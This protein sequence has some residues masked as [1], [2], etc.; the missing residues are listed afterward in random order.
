MNFCNDCRVHTWVIDRYAYFPVIFPQQLRAS[1]EELAEKLAVFEGLELDRQS[2][3]QL[4]QEVIVATTRKE[5]QDQQRV[6]LQ[7]N[8]NLQSQMARLKMVAES[9]TSPLPAHTATNSVAADASAED[10][11]FAAVMAVE[12]RL[13]QMDTAR[14]E[15]ETKLQNTKSNLSLE[16]ETRKEIQ[17]QQRV[18]VEKNDKLHSQIVEQQQNLQKNTTLQS[19]MAEQQRDLTQT[20]E[21]LQSQIVEQQRALNDNA[22]LQSQTAEQQSTLLQKT[23]QLQSQMTE[24]QRTLLQTNDNLQSQIAEQQRNLMQTTDKLQSQIAEQQRNLLHTNDKLQSQ[25]AEQQRN[26]MQTNDK[27]QSQMSEQQRNLLHTNDTLQSQ[28]TKHQRTLQKNENLQSQMARLKMVADSPTSPLPAHTATNSVS[29][30]LS[31]G[32]PEFAA[33]LAVE[34]RLRQMDT[35][36]QELETKLKSMQS[37]VLFESKARQELHAHATERETK[38]KQLMQ[39]M[40]ES[41]V[42][43]LRRDAEAAVDAAVTQV[44]RQ[45]VHQIDRRLNPVC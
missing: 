12:R 28:R 26:L 16:S 9:P 34:R 31:A 4:E 15:L 21:K 39:R 13:R 17:E 44:R 35:A 8:A 19:Q 3:Y 27:L 43:K 18:L 20:N 25:I 10:P 14:Q 33:V 5:M 2:N 11:E 32:E 42:E 29:A 45:W 1:N 23:D 24:Q 6:L 37:K 40:L 36:R 41:A 7:K 30:V 38:M 22:K